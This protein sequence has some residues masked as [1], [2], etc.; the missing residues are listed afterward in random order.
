MGDHARKAAKEFDESEREALEAA[1]SHRQQVL[2]VEKIYMPEVIRHIHKRIAFI[3]HSLAHH[4]EKVKSLG[5][6]KIA[7]PAKIEVAKTHELRRKVAAEH[8]NTKLK[9]QR[10]KFLNK[11]VKKMRL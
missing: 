5:K 9:L 4:L 2:E 6:V 7:T 1:K 8:A 11:K 10:I 3:E